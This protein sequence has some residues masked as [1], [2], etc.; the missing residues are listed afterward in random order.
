MHNIDRAGLALLKYP[1][2]VFADD[3]Q[4]Q[5]IETYRKQDEEENRGDSGRRRGEYAELSKI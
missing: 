2:D 1:P 4:K 3:S 5:R